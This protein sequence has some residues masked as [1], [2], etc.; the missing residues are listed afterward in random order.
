MDLSII[1]VNYN[2]LCFMIACLAS[3]AECLK[4]GG[5]ET[6]LID[7]GSING[8]SQL[9]KEKF[10]GLSFIEN[11]KNLGFAR[12]VNQGFAIAKGKYLLIL[13]PDIKLLPGSVEKAIHFLDKNPEVGLLLPKL[14]NPDGSLQFS[15]RTFYDFPTLLFRR[16]PLGKIFPNHP[17]IRRHLMMDWDHN[18]VRKVDWGLGASMVI[19]REALK[20][21]KVFDERFFLY[22]EDV[23]LCFSLKKEG[24]KVVYCP[25]VV[26]VHHHVRQSAQGFMNRER[27]EHFKSLLKF[28]CKHL[29]LSY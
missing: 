8:C 6:I 22:F 28:Y 2:S 7:N 21:G 16:T 10:P 17:V 29:K 23:D 27:W 1:V 14:V 11:A 18:E 3:I 20:G 15:C 13:N 26:M 19:R 24:W 4:P 12:A 9:I 5:H 25:N